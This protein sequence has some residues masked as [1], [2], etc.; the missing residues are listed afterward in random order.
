[1]I[2]KMNTDICPILNVGMCDT[3]ISPSDRLFYLFSDIIEESDIL[4]P[5]EEKYYDETVYDYFDREAYEQR[6]AEIARVYI[7]SF[8]E[9]IK[10]VVSVKVLPE[11]NINSPEEYNYQNDEL[12]F[13]IEIAESELAKIRENVRKDAEKFFDWAAK[14]K[15]RDGFV[16][17][18]PY[19]EN[20]WYAA[21]DGR[22]TARAISMYFEYLL[23]QGE[24][25]FFGE[26]FLI[27]T[28]DESD[29][30]YQ[31][32]FEDDVLEIDIDE[33]IVDKKCR[34]IINKAVAANTKE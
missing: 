10:D 14:Y 12:E 11:V 3:H 17:F 1:M 6:V 19:W 4:T 18:M 31:R 7:E 23:E 34:Q 26:K 30:V 21:I 15:T 33:F 5:E 28:E 27:L 9:H 25:E 32:W 24:K 13:K 29:T 2:I 16:S 22:D 20:G 8:F